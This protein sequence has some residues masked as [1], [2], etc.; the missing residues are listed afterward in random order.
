M[1]CS[2]SKGKARYLHNLVLV[3]TSRANVTADA[4]TIQP[5]GLRIEQ[6]T[7]LWEGGSA[8]SVGLLTLRGGL[9]A[10]EAW[11]SLDENLEA[12]EWRTTQGPSSRSTGP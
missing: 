10:P 6:V 12:A 7:F 2:K 1:R 4:G 8:V 5:R 11:G 3:P 9:A